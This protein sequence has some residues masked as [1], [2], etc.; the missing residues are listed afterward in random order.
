MA[1]DLVK[2]IAQEQKPANEPIRVEVKRKN[3]VDCINYSTQ[4]YLKNI[5]N[6][7]REFLNKYF[8]INYRA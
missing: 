7:D 4:L 3:H 5:Q 1:N 8:N 2:R 6:L